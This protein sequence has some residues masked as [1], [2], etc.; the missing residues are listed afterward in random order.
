MAI[1]G[2]LVGKVHIKIVFGLKIFGKRIFPAIQ[3]CL[4]W[5]TYIVVWDR[6]D[7]LSQEN[8]RCLDGAASHQSFLKSCDCPLSPKMCH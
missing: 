1:K 5:T 3:V 4:R 2:I 8:Y 7:E 6:D